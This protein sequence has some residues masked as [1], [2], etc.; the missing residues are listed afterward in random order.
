MSSAWH[1]GS[2]LSML[3]PSF[4]KDLPFGYSV[5]WLGE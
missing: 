4:G 3:V 1:G 2:A 5:D